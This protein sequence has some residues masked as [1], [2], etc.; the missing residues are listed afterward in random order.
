MATASLGTSLDTH[1]VWSPGSLRRTSRQEFEI[2]RQ[3]LLLS[4]LQRSHPVH[5]NVAPAIR[6]PA[7]TNT[8]LLAGLSDTEK[9]LLQN[10]IAPAPSN[11]DVLR[12]LRGQL[13]ADEHRTASV[14]ASLVAREQQLQR[15]ASIMRPIAG[16]SQSSPTTMMAAATGTTT[17]NRPELLDSMLARSALGSQIAGLAGLQP[18]TTSQ[19]ALES[20]NLAALRQHQQTWASSLSP[21]TSLYFPIREG[22][23]PSS[24]TAQ[25]GP[26][27]DSWKRLRREP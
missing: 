2:E 4:S 16:S 8:P 11:A 14:I 18:T 25:A 10:R 15:Q 17:R 19:L 22:R 3:H 20:S 24:P 12:Q 23:K 5:Q 13:L 21:T 26:P 6:M 9:A 27:E 1:R 7:F